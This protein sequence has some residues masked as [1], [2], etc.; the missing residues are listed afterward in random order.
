MP[1]VSVLLPCRNAAAALAEAATSLER[2]H[3]RDF[4]VL[5]VDDGSSDTTPD[6]LVAWARR[7]PRVRV[8]RQAPRG[9]VAALQTAAAEARGDLLARM[10]ADDISHPERLGRQVALL[11]DRPTLAACG[12]GVRYFPRER[13]RDGARRYERWLNS[14][15]EPSDLARDMFVEC[16]IAHPTLMV[17]ARAFSDAGG[18]REAGWPEDYDLVLRLWA[19]G[20]HLANVPKVLLEWREDAHRISRSDPRYHADAFRRCKVHWLLRTLLRPAEDRRLRPA[21]VWGAGPVGKSF[22]LELLRQGVRVAAFVD[23]DPRKMGQEI[24]GARV[25][26]PE[27]VDA[28]RHGLVLGAVGAPGGRA[29]IRAALVER[30]WTELVD[31]VMV[32]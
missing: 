9:I 15:V 7:D 13:V 8:I 20:C 26:A 27:A 2:Q 5:A 6:Q 17:R 23:L 31:Y 18:Y 4:E 16:P 11:D 1:R 32:A 12:T 21:V 10:D 25:I 19:A 14:L 28:Y 30:G 22:A 29:A 24:H 3:Y